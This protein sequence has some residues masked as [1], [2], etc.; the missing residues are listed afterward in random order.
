[1]GKVDTT[2]LRTDDLAKSIASILN[3]AG[4]TV[5]LD[6]KAIWTASEICAYYRIGRDTLR[7]YMAKGLPFVTISGSHKFERLKVKKYFERQRK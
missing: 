1:M 2:S 7:D 5:P 3:A 4:S 6:L